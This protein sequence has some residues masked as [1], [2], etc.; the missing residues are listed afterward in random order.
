MTYD[1]TILLISY[2]LT[3][4]Y[5][6]WVIY[7]VFT[8]VKVGNLIT[9]RINEKLC[10]FQGLILIGK[11]ISA[12]LS[13]N[14]YRKKIATFR[15]LAYN[16]SMN[17]ILIYL[18]TP[19]LLLIYVLTNVSLITGLFLY[20]I[21]YYLIIIRRKFLP[22]Y[23]RIQVLDE[24]IEEAQ[25][26]FNGLNERE[27]NNPILLKK[28]I[29]TEHASFSK[30]LA[31]YN[32]KVFDILK[33]HTCER[34]YYIIENIKEV[35]LRLLKRYN[36]NFGIKILTPKVILLSPSYSTKLNKQI[37]DSIEKIDIE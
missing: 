2:A 12:I 34:N 23:S 24:E 29:I 33:T 1:E 13:L 27:L 6:I 20:F 17:F 30:N 15:S 22:I 11:P 4:S 35:Y 21:G 28:L 16:S 9:L 19:T 5:L 31:D 3:L 32:I 7:Q 37:L 36:W 10:I 25:R 8:L 26:L 14:P 18:A